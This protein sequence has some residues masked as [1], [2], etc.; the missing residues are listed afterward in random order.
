M[1]KIEI[2]NQTEEDI[3]E[4]IEEI[5]SKVECETIDIYSVLK[6]HKDEY[7][8]YNDHLY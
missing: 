1:N 3:K 2:F 4:L 7:I 6:E 5:Y 8:F